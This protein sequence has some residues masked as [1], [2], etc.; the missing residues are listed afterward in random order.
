MKDGALRLML[1]A[2]LDGVV[3]PLGQVPD[4]VFAQG[5]MGDGIAIE[6]LSDR[7]LAPCDGVV[8]TLHAARH[9][10]TLR[11]DAGVDILIHVGLETVGLNGDGFTTLVGEG[12]RVA[13]GTPLI[14]FELDRIALAAPS[15]ATPVVIM[16][17]ACCSIVARAEGKVRAG[18]P[19]L[20]LEVTAPSDV[21]AFN[22]GADDRHSRAIAIP[23]RHGIHARPAAR[24]SAALKPFSARVTLSTEERTAD[25]RSTVALLALGARLGDIVKI[26]AEGPDAVAALDAVWDLINSGMGETGEA[27]E[28]PSPAATMPLSAEQRPGALRGVCASPG[29]AMGVAHRLAQDEPPLKEKG[30]SVA[31]EQARLTD[32]LSITRAQISTRAVQGS[33]AQRAI[34]TAHLAILEDPAL[35]ETAQREI[36]AGFS[37]AFAWH[38]TIAE[39]AATL[40]ALEDERLRERA[41][42]LKDLDRQVRRALSG[43]TGNDRRL[44]ENAV[45]IA[46]DLLPSQLIEL[47]LSRLAGFCLAQ[48]GPTSHVAILA[49]GMGL[50]SLVAVGSGL[51]A[52]K[53]ESRLILDAEAGWLEVDPSGDR[54]AEI[55]EVI[56]ARHLRRAAA[57]RDADTPCVT[58][59]GRRIEIFA[60]LGSVADAGQ[61]ACQGA[62]GAGLVRTEFLFLD[63]QTAPDEEEQRAVY[64]AI[65]EALPG[66]PVIARLL[67]I[68]GDKPVPYLATAREDNPMLGV[69]GIR[70][71]LRHPE[72]LTTQLRAMLAVRPAGQLRI[73][74]PMVSTVDEIRQVRVILDGLVD[75]AG[76]EEAPQ[77]GI[78]IE[79]PA[80]AATADLLAAEADFLSIG[81]NDL[82]Q[83]VL[84]LDRGN[85][86]LAEGVDP[87]HPAVL[88]MIKATCD[89]A[90]KHKRPVGV[91][92]G[93]AGDPEAVPLLMGLGA[94][95]LSMVPAAIPEMKAHV[96]S[97]S[98]GRM[99]ALVERALHCTDAAQVRALVRAFERDERS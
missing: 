69:R 85:A 4:P 68:G 13:A 21:S 6:P 44:P 62:E 30:G 80:A 18:D 38:R 58:A 45:L 64:Q 56:A 51:N 92:G 5:M 79:T 10:V 54:C 81:T 89:G 14:A 87:L 48:G 8:A 60:N 32:S 42:D 74:I 17:G 26:E 78:M 3:T 59:D 93:A 71:A 88:R 65:V 49:A 47:D 36:E 94:T 15:L 34:L 77:L 91:C 16:D 67:D 72:V 24:I 57:L 75:A 41:A 33:D 61:A 23:M 76:L 19:L 27:A 86:S 97:L 7:V 43:E 50:P 84:A 73:M 63:R 82:T 66:R 98:Q 29:V 96:R 28:L 39:Q 40:A 20:T 11:S 31:E 25:G 99:R 46:D 1:C 9:A 83:Y 55:A 70:L 35:L 95:E 12:E 53:D 22:V 2:P 90:A 37:A 52:I